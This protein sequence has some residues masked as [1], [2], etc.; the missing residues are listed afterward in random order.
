MTLPDL[1]RLS[2]ASLPDIELYVQSNPIPTLTR[3]LRRLAV[4]LA[5]VGFHPHRCVISFTAPE[6]SH[7]MTDDFILVLHRRVILAPFTLH[8]TIPYL[9][10]IK[11]VRKVGYD[12]VDLYKDF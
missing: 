6:S 9:R 1:L 7:N 12:I 8:R 11:Y 5:A 10:F 2:S 3:P 4:R